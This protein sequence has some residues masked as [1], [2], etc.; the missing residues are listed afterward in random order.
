MEVILRKMKLRLVCSTQNNS[1]IEYYLQ[2]I[3]KIIREIEEK[4]RH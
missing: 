4:K 1:R 2:N 3:K